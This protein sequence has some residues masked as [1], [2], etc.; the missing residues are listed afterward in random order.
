MINFFRKIREKL[1]SEGKTGKYLKYAIG[2]IVLVMIGILLALQVNNWNQERLE[3]KLEAKYVERLKMNLQQDIL[4]FA[5]FETT[6]LSIKKG[7]L[8]VL[9]SAK[10]AEDIIHNPVITGENLDLSTAIS[11]PPIQSTTYEEL[12]NNGDIRLIRNPDIRL[13]LDEY[14]DLVE[15]ISGILQKSP[16]TYLQILYGSLPGQSTY[17]S[18][19]NKRDYTIPEMEIGFNL[20]LN[21]KGKQEAVNL[22]LYYTA[23]LSYW[24]NRIS[25]MAENCLATLELEYPEN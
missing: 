9:G 7:V 1:L 21:H 15:L 14:Y 22:E 2:E 11:L 12:K 6:Y 8:E 3:R 17:E 5:E 25:T 20:F 10:D 16:G 18:L 23:S 24:L 13:K 19:I 4:T